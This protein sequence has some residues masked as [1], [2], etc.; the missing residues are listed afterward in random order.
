M[1]SMRFL[2][3]ILVAFAAFEARAVA[4][5]DCIG[6]EGGTVTTPGSVLQNALYA[7]NGGTIVLC[8]QAQFEVS[9]SIKVP[10]FSK[11][12]TRGLPTND[13]LKARIFYK[14]GSGLVKGQ[15][16]LDAN[17]QSGVELRNL[18]VDGS[19]AHPAV[20][21]ITGEETK[22]RS[23]IAI[24]GVNSLMDRVR[25]V[26]PVG[27]AIVAAADDKNCSGLRITNSFFGYAVLAPTEI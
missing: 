3:P 11:I 4:R 7:A 15:A 26:N 14:P 25:A 17:G 23:L 18:I 6:D 9:G 5:P 22:H 1:K 10:A 27:M 2:V 20:E 16:V 12:Q 13:A 19:R 8:Q 21:R 24:S